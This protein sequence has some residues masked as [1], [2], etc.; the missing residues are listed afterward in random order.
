MMVVSACK[1]RQRAAGRKLKM[2][3]SSDANLRPPHNLFNIPST[4]WVGIKILRNYDL[5]FSLSHHFSLLLM[6]FR[7]SSFRIKSCGSIKMCFGAKE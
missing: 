5:N 7:S 4:A 2:S 6:P 1:A 3:S